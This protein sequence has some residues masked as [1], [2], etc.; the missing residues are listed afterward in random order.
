MASNNWQVFLFSP[1]FQ[2]EWKVHEARMEE[3]LFPK[4]DLKMFL[5]EREIDGFT[6]GFLSPH[7]QFLS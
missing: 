1:M 6:R 4:G 5:V 7:L 2:S 3:N